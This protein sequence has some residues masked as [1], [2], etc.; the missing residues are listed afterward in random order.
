MPLYKEETASTM[1]ETV[2]KGH[3]LIDYTIPKDTAL[4]VPSTGV[5]GAR[6]QGGASLPMCI[7]FLPFSF[8]TF[9][10]GQRLQALEEGVGEM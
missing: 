6:V 5:L 7:N 3:H 8:M 2:T 10:S 4:Q 1:E 9:Q